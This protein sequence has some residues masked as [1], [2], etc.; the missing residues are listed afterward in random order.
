MSSPS[1]LAPCVQQLVPELVAELVL[2]HRAGDVPT[3]LCA[4]ACV[5]RAWRAAAAEPHLW[6]D[7]RWGRAAGRLTDERLASLVAR[8]A[9]GLTSMEPFPKDTVV[10]DFGVADA[11]QRL[12]APLA[13][14]RVR[15]VHTDYGSDGSEEDEQP[16]Y[17]ALRALVK[18]S[19]SG[20]D[21]SHCPC[22]LMCTQAE[23]LCGGMPHAINPHIA[24][25][26]TAAQPPA[27]GAAKPL[28]ASLL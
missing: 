22:K 21:V 14:L 19:D 23:T 26:A 5:A 2:R 8:S 1:A 20:L 16:G 9:G 28:L 24:P 10:T 11:P 13:R 6:R 12:V 17:M 3:L 15:G 18:R 25:M 7:L 4:A 27:S